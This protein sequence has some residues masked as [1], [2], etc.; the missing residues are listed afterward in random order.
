MFSLND[1]AVVADADALDSIPK[2]YKIFFFL[3]GVSLC[4]VSSLF[5][6]LLTN[7]VSDS[8]ALFIL[9]NPSVYCFF[10][11]LNHQGVIHNSAS[12]KA[13]EKGMLNIVSIMS[14]LFEIT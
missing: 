5:S 7:H 1:K 10:R 13:G 8:S 4:D 12:S 14:Q 9:Q 11:T 6:L 2:W 3:C